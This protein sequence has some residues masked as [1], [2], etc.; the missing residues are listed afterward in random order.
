VPGAH[1]QSVAGVGHDLA[2]EVLGPI[3]EAS[4]R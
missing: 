1:Y 3:V 4:L 2:P